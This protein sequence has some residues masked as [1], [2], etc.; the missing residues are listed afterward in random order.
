MKSYYR[1]SEL[2]STFGLSEADLQYLCTDTEVS[3]CLYCKTQN[4]V[5]GGW[6][7]GKFNGFGSA[8]YAGLISMTKEQ[9]FEL[10]EKNKISI[11]CST[12][13]Q[14]NKIL[15]YSSDYPF[16]VEIP[17]GVI[18]KWFNVTFEQLPFDRASFKN[19]PFIFYPQERT[20]MLKDFERFCE[21][22]AAM[23]NPASLKTPK[24]PNEIELFY[25]VKT[26]LLEDVCITSE[27]LENVKAHFSIDVSPSV[28]FE[29]KVVEVVTQK[30]LPSTE[31]KALKASNA[32]EREYDL[33]VLIADIVAFNKFIT[34]KEVWSI[35]EEESKLQN[36]ERE[37]DKYNILKAVVD[38]EL[39][40]ESRYGRSGKQKFS[41][42]NTTLSRIKKRTKCV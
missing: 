14:K 4:I 41:S 7:K 1:I 18:Q 26:F 16:S 13:L 6:S 15:H 24:K 5:I 9:Q 19:M 17:N 30:S 35:L 31:F 22:V 29:N 2:Q 8:K 10:F 39:M 38:D 37:F 12:L 3:F 42:L 11:R 20:S 33:N 40:W 21:E 28:K 27:E 36:S 25:S 23:A 32:K 34:A